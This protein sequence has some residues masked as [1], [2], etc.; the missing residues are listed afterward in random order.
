MEQEHL[1]EAACLL[2]Q[3]ALYRKRIGLNSNI[4]G[5][6]LVFAG[7]KQGAFSLYFGDAP[8]FHFDLEGRWQ[9]AFL[10]GVHYLKG[11]D[12]DIHAIDRLREGANLVLHRRRVAYEEASELDGRIRSVALSIQ[13]DL[14][15]NRL[16]FRQ[17]PEGK[18]EPLSLDELDESLDQIGRWDHAAWFAHRER[19]LGTYGPLPFLPPDSL[20]AV[21]FQATLGQA[22]DHGF[23]MG[24]GTEFYVRTPDE[25]ETHVREVATLWGR[26]LAQSRIAFL[27]GGDVLSLSATEVIEYFDAIGRTFTIQ[28]K[29]SNHMMKSSEGTPK[30]SQFEG[31]HVF[32][33]DPSLPKRNHVDWDQLGA[34]GLVRLSI[35]VESGDNEVRGIWGKQWKDEDLRS[36]VTDL[37]TAGIAVSLLTLIGAGGSEFA[38]THLRKTSE[39]I[40]ALGLSDGDHVFLLDEREIRGSLAPMQNLTQLEGPTWAIHQKRL[41]EKLS[42]IRNS[43]VKVSPYSLA[44]QWA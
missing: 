20:N 1:T 24:Q 13:A 40:Q 15:A 22:T 6:D 8:I 41:K 34:R 12:G 4:P 2:N 5:G 35:G 27:A 14:G 31:I 7:I 44:K 19:Y 30:P 23:G 36:T 26:R 21:V 3:G 32:I 17:P 18:A 37:K 9:R 16:A 29:S 10:E 28:R 42:P 43:G 11:L 38:E 39:L 33:D 25:F